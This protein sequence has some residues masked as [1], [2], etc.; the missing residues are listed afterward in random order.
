MMGRR[1]FLTTTA[2]GLAAAPAILA[3][4]PRRTDIRI[5][6]V[7]TGLAYYHYRVPIKFGGVESDSAT[8]LNVNC[9][10]SAKSGKS[11]KGFGSMP[12]GN[13][14]SFPSRLVSH[15]AT[16][17]A[18]KNLAERISR[19]TA[20]YKEYGHPID[21]NYALQPLYLKAAEAVSSE[22]RLAEPVPRLCTEVTAS[23]F[24]AAMHDAFGKLHGLNCYS[25][26]GPEFMAHDLSHYA[27]AEY[28]GE[29][30][31]TYLLK[32]PKP[33][34]PLYHLVGAV[35]ALEHADLKQR[36]GD[37]LPETLAEW[38]DFNGLTHLKIKLNGDD[39]R[40]D[41]ER[42]VRVDR[43]TSETQRIRGVREW[44]YSLDFNERCPNVQYLVDFLNRV[45]VETPAGFERI[46]YVE[47]PTARDLKAHRENAMHAASRIKPVVIDESLTDLES[48]MLARQMGYTGAALKACKGQSFMMIAASVAER[49]K[50]FLCV[51]DLTC[52]GASLIQSAGLAAHV[53]HVQAIEANARQYMPAANRD[54]EKRFP[55]VF[56]IKDGTME[57][58]HLNG[59]GLGAV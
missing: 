49:Q 53:P 34:L 16:L 39:A 57:T 4:A 51:Q 21:L 15:A 10:V 26:Y 35:D 36:V 18:M 24:D 37:G 22:M 32:E 7:S 55:G 46:Q 6:E 9:V 52:P 14:W 41:V 3:A 43:I 25:T 59:L 48:M 47:Q 56:I 11:A 38:I 31:S 58:A 29:Y 5:E 45:K 30:P 12:L 42:V 20:G 33:R 8:L 17:E 54:W 40:W 1:K 28:R 44:V 19:I 13:A 2:A 23:A 50:M 27:G